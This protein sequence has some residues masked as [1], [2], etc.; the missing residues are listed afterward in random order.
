MRRKM[1][2]RR[3]PA[4]RRW[5]PASPA[6]GTGNRFS[7]HPVKTWT[8]IVVATLIVFAAATETLLHAI[9]PVETLPL[10]IRASDPPRAIMLREWQ[11]GVTYLAAPP[12]IRRRNPGGPVHDVYELRIDANGFIEPSAVHDTPDKT[13]VFLGGSTTEALYVTPEQRFP[14]L[15]GRALDEKTGYRVNTLNGGRSGNDLAHVLH[16]L[17][18]KVLPLRPDIVVV[19]ENINDRGIAQRFTTY[20]N[21]DTSQ[22]VIVAPERSV[23]SAFRALRD[24]LVP[25]TYRLFKRAGQAIGRS[26][27]EGFARL[28]DGAAHAAGPEDAPGVRAGD[29][30]GDGAGGAADRVEATPAPEP[31]VTVSSDQY[32]RMLRTIVRAAKAWDVAPVLM[33]Q[34]LLSADVA[35]AGTGGADDYLAPARL[36]ATGLNDVSLVTDQDRF[37]D[38]VRRVASE[39]GAAL[40]DLAADAGWTSDHFYDRIHFTDAGSARAAALIAAALE[41]LIGHAPSPEPGA[42]DAPASAPVPASGPDETRPAP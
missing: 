27:D 11:P 22:G 32:E 28:G 2:R 42:A 38:V 29:G 36:A 24:S 34:V 20:W 30:A 7:A 39:E 35:L 19:M 13:V 12:L 3:R 40:V 4:D 33:T 16:L 26:V 21:A 5:S 8:A 23:G 37:N 14:V 1:F 41:P 10:G 9:E 6:L 15:V 25:R 31:A 17:T 18:G